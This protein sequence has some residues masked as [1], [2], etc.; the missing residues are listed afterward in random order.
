MPHIHTEYNQH[1][2]TV[3]A[4]I[5]R[6]DGSEPKILLHMHRKLHILLPV[7]GHVELSETPWQAIEHEI[8]EESGYVLGQLEVLQP[9]SR[10]KRISNV[11][12]H[13]YPVSLNTHKVP[14]DH[15]HTDLEY[16]FI[17]RSDPV[18]NIEEGESNDMRW[19]NSNE[20]DALS[21]EMI[22]D[23]TKEVYRFILDEALVNW[24]RV[25]SEAFLVD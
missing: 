4:Y 13:P 11:I 7:G 1:D 23:N 15:F 5:V 2:L 24:D 8:V 9:K 19:L 6:I 18:M 14:G 12:R 16:A 20:L 25:P 22:F 3:S 10:I 21:S 17:A